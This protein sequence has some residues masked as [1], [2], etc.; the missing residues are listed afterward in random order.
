MRGYFHMPTMLGF[1]WRLQPQQT[2]NRRSFNFYC[3]SKTRFLLY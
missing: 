1:D 3:S 2:I